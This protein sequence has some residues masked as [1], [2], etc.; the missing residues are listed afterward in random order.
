MLGQVNQDW[1]AVESISVLVTHM[2]LFGYTPFQSRSDASVLGSDMG[3]IEP[4]M[5]PT[6]IRLSQARIGYELN[7]IHPIPIQVGCKCLGPDMV[8]LSQIWSRYGSE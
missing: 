7:W 4:G 8:R 5:D 1:I 6:W 2:E 3:S